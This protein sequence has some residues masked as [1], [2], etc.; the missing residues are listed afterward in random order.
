M[1]VPLITIALEEEEMVDHGA[2]TYGQKLP[3]LDSMMTAIREGDGCS[4]ASRLPNICMPNPNV[5]TPFLRFDVKFRFRLSAV[6][7]FTIIHVRISLSFT[8]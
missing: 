2:K 5:R 1:M 3:M 4:Q 8:S 7:Q 6:P